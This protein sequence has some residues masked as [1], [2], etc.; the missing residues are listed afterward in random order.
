MSAIYLVRHGQA[1]FG[2]ADYDQLSELGVRQSTLLG[3]WLAQTGQDM[4]LLVTG[5]HRRHQQSSAAC[6]AALSHNCGTS[7][8]QQLQDPGFDEFDHQQVLL[9]LMPQFADRAVLAAYLAEQENPARAFQQV[10]AKAVARWVGGEHD[11]DYS[12]TWPQFKARCNAALARLLECIGSGQ[13]AWVFTSGGP[14]SAICQRLLAIPDRQIFELNWSLVN[15]GVT[16]LLYRPGRVSLSYLNSF[17]HLENARDA[18]LVSY[19]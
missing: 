1:S 12:E 10:F 16:K 7:A 14:I 4:P 15:T 5:S 3:Q 18:T 6:L 8:Q 13:S 2:A 19:R 17:A 9:R 11:E